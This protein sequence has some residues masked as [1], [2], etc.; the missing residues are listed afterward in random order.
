MPNQTLIRTLE[1]LSFRAWPPLYTRYYDGWLLRFAERYTR[2]ANSI[3][4]LYTSSLA[5][6][7]KIDFCENL[8]ADQDQPVYVK[9]NDWAQPPDLDDYLSD[10]AYVRE[11]ASGVML[12]DLKAPNGHH[13]ETVSVAT[14]PSEAWLSAYQRLNDLSEQHRAVHQRM[15]NANRIQRAY[16]ALSGPEA[17]DQG[18]APIISLGM[19]VLEDGFL[20]LYDVATDPAYRRQGYARDLVG[21]MMA[22][23]RIWG[24]RQAY[25]QVTV[26]N[27]PALNL[28]DALGFREVYR[29]WYRMKP[30]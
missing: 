11:A 18:E 16:F 19:A 25:L 20:G 15:L 7:D 6:T 2:R 1:E 22:W 30:V 4:P 21:S 29:Y 9:M 12:L 8:Y 28:Y 13:N 3:S 10:R 23:G 24:A 17:N 26:D 27:I 14:R 5:L